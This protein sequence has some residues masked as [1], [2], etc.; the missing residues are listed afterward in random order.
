MNELNEKLL[1]QTTP[2]KG[3][4]IDQLSVVGRYL[5]S[6]TRDIFMRLLYHYT[7]MLTERA[8]AMEMAEAEEW[9]V[10]T[11]MEKIDV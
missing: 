10:P 3:Y 4:E 1:A 2:P 7:A 8:I 6:E 9:N 11:L 5:N